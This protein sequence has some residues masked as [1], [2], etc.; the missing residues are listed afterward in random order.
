MRYD[1]A[2][3]DENENGDDATDDLYQYKFLND[4]AVMKTDLTLMSEDLIN[5]GLAAGWVKLELGVKP[6][7][8]PS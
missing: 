3:N 6:R 2:D 4:V 7:L 1:E 5:R 8:Q